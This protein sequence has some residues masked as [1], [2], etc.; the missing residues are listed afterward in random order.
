MKDYFY[1]IQIVV[2]RHLFAKACFSA[3]NPLCQREIASLSGFICKVDKYV[4]FT[5]NE[6]IVFQT[7]TIIVPGQLLSREHRHYNQRPRPGDSGTIQ[8]RAGKRNFKDKM[9]TIYKK[10]YL[11]FY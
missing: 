4:I 9:L 8:L 7:S 1:R 5:L 3:R 10:L 2:A 11:T 6:Y